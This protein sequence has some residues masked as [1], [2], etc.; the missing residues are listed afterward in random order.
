MAARAAIDDGDV[1]GAIE[2]VNQM[3]P[4]LLENNATLLFTLQLQRLIE[5]I[6]FDEVEA[7]LNFAQEYL[8]PLATESVRGTRA[9]LRVLTWLTGL[10]RLTG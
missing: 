3:D 5:L 6:S 4:E 8:A 10:G 7:A 9:C 2:L 1:A